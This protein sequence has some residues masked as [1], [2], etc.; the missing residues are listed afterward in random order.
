MEYGEKVRLSSLYGEVGER[1]LTP[2]DV[3]VILMALEYLVMED[4]KFIREWKHMDGVEPMIIRTTQEI[5]EIR[6]LKAKVCRID[7]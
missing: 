3:A 7:W 2:H 6:E 5:E 4:E 1:R